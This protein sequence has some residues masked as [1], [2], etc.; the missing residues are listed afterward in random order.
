MGFTRPIGWLVLGA[1]LMPVSQEKREPAP[2]LPPVRKMTLTWDGK[3]PAEALQEFA[4]LSGF[5]LEWLGT[6]RSKSNID[7][8]LPANPLSVSLRDCPWAEA[9]TRLPFDFAAHERG[10]DL[11]VDLGSDNYG[12]S[13]SGLFGLRITELNEVIATDFTRET[14]TC[15]L[16]VRVWWQPDVHVYAVGPAHVTEASDDLGTDLRVQSSSREYSRWAREAHAVITVGLP[17]KAARRIARINGSLDVLVP[18]DC[19]EFALK[20]LIE[21]PVT[22]RKDG[23][24]VTLTRG[25]PKDDIVEWSIV[26]QGID[27]GGVEDVLEL[28][29]LNKEG[30]AHARPAWHRTRAGASLFCN[31]NEDV[32]CIALRVVKNRAR[33][34]VPFEFKDVLLDRKP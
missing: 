29:T 4:R 13:C 14:R 21:A 2:V 18:G 8:R 9:I 19:V 27:G 34:R 24:A 20:N 28:R 26:V 3:P 16:D 30:K 12:T 33:V 17:P 11:G 10:A 22:E 5:T 1:T 25:L 23:V 32:D 7:R 15:D 6:L 31:A